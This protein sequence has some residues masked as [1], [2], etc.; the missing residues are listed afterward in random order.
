MLT[1]TA[2]EPSSEVAK[3]A[4]VANA[5]TLD[6]ERT[7]V[8]CATHWV[9]FSF[10]ATSRGVLRCKK[11]K[12]LMLLFSLCRAR[13]LSPRGREFTAPKVERCGGE[14]NPVGLHFVTRLCEHCSPV[15]TM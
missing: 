15:R 14:Q 5:R 11:L 2:G 8:R 12:K 1:S 3:A 6:A 7:P 13:A 10:P 9:A 4:S